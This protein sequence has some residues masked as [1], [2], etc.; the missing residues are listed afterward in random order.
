[1]LRHAGQQECSYTRKYPNHTHTITVHPYNDEDEDDSHTTFISQLK[2]EAF[3][4]TLRS[5]T[6]HNQEFYLN[7]A[8]LPPSIPL[9][10][11]LFQL[12]TIA[13]TIEH[14]FPVLGGFHALRGVI[15]SVNKV[16]YGQEADSET[17]FTI[18]G[19][20]FMN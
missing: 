20:L 1:M 15:N 16:L 6:K 19:H 5:T 2:R 12:A 10:H 13:D 17:L 14:V 11:S 18:C 3:Q 9:H 7:S 4:E 8:L